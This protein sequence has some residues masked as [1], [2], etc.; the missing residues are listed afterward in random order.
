VRHPAASCGGRVRHHRH[1]RTLE[2][3]WQVIFRYVSAKLDALISF[4]LP[5]HGFDITRRLRMIS[6]SDYEFGLRHFFSQEIESLY[7]Q[8]EAFISS[9]LSESQDAV[10]RISPSREIGE[11]R[12]S[13]QNSVRPQMNVVASVLIVQNLP[14]AWHKH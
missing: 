3:F 10:N 14:V 9:P 12:P 4:A 2:Q 1:S 11:F 5:L 7:H 6:S 13:R 8:L